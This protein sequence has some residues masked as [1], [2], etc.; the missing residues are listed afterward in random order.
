MVEVV[1][2]KQILDKYNI[3][4]PE[5]TP[6]IPPQHILDN[7]LADLKTLYKGPNPD[8]PSF[9]KKY[10]FAWRRH[11]YTGKFYGFS[12]GFGLADP[13]KELE[14]SD[15]ERRLSLQTQG[16][17]IKLP[18]QLRDHLTKVSRELQVGSYP[19]VFSLWVDE[20]DK[21][22]PATKP[23]EFDDSTDD[24][25]EM[26]YVGDGG[27]DGYYMTLEGKMYYRSAYGYVACPGTYIC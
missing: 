21:W 20:E 3:S 8:H 11:Y 10:S 23:E 25:G 14:I 26:F 9:L 12:Y 4:T 27:C 6:V 16:L 19:L 15:Y 5:N 2:Y 1:T 7:L 24:I 17:C 22:V 13:Y 18:R